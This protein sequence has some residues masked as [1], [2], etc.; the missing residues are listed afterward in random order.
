MNGLEQLFYGEE[1]KAAKNHPLV[2]SRGTN[3]NTGFAPLTPAQNFLAT[4]LFEKFDDAFE[5]IWKPLMDTVYGTVT[6]V[7]EKA[8]KDYSAYVVK[9]VKNCE[10]DIRKLCA[11]DKS[12]PKFDDD[13]LRVIKEMPYRVELMTLGGLID[14]SSGPVPVGSPMLCI[15]MYDAM[16]QVWKSQQDAAL[17]VCHLQVVFN[18]SMSLNCPC[19]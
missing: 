15:N 6:P 12:S 5:A 18:T 13:M 19:E 10:A 2:I 16:K 17:V 1:F 7:T 8:T 14:A 4:W 11:E 9:S 3:L